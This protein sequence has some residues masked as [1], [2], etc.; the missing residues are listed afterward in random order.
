MN[1]QAQFKSKEILKSSFVDDVA[2]AIHLLYMAD[3]SVGEEGD[4]L[5][6]IAV[7]AYVPSV[8]L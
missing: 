5:D 6:H 1:T 3:K 2:D 8:L 7:I 4:H